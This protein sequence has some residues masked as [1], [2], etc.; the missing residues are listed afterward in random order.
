MRK[1]LPEQ[2]NRIRREVR[3]VKQYVII[4]NGTA[5]IG[6]IEGIRSVDTTAN[7]TVISKEKHPCYCR[8]LISYYMEEKTDPVRMLYRSESFYADNGA[9]VLYGEEAV[10]IDPS[11]K[12]VVLASGS[13]VPYDALCIAAGSS[14][15]VP[16][17]EN[18]DKVE[19]K[20]S[21]M[22]LDDAEDLIKALTPDTRL[23]IIG[24]G[25]IGL[26]CAEGAHHITDKITV[27]DLAGHVLSSILEKEDA[28]VVQ[29]H[30]EENGVK[31]LLSDSVASFD[32]NCAVMKSGAKVEFDVLVTAVGVRAN[33]QLMKDAG[34]ACGR[35]ITVSDRMETS[36]EGIYAAGDCTEYNDISDESV[37][38]MALMPNAYIGGKTAG[39][40]M[41][42]G[43]AA[44]DNAIPMNSI[45]FF[46]YH[47]M[48][49]GSRNGEI[50]KTEDGKNRKKFFIRDGK[51]VGFMILG[52]VKN[53]G[54]LTSLIRNRIPLDSLVDFDLEKTP[55]ISAFDSE[56]RSKFLESVV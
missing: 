47:I 11:A 36:L 53:T 42:G 33:I 19:K 20:F 9:E 48:T 46:G 25:L 44:F 31:F 32:G 12:K 7:I 43:E 23:L 54:I 34:G 10:K 50:K 30:L 41:A 39:I 24:A 5:A 49:A 3:V 1:G 2:S 51:L 28:E 8:P 29:A 40:N 18:L 21:F 35:A 27:C 37:K 38:V 4:G 13:I 26:K 15:F 45:G 17:M 55:A 56:N 22:T 16:P 6:T 14:P 52:D